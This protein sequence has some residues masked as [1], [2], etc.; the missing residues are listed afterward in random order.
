MQAEVRKTGPPD[1]P[2]TLV[3]KS[4]SMPAPAFW[5]YTTRREAEREAEALRRTKR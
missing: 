3:W 5:Y 1:R 2:Y 4:P